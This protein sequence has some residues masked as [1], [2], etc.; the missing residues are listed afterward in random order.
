MAETAVSILPWPEIIT[1]G[2]LGCCSLI[3]CKQLQAVEPRPLHPDVEKDQMRPAR[4]DGGQSLVGILGRARAV[5]FVG[6][7]AGDDFANIGLVVDDEDVCR[8]EVSAP[9]MWRRARRRKG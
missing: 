4:L 8:H 2:R 3:T 5:P 9:L 6:K 1:T 7:N